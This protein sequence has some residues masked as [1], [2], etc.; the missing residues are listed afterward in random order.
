MTAALSW[1]TMIA[2]F[3]T[4][5]HRSEVCYWRFGLLIFAITTRAD[6]GLSRDRI[7][8]LVSRT[9]TSFASNSPEQCDLF[10]RISK[11][12]W[13]YRGPCNF[14]ESGSQTNRLMPCRSPSYER[15]LT[16]ASHPW[17]LRRVPVKSSYLR[18]DI[19]S[20][21][22]SS[23]LS[24]CTVII[25]ERSLPTHSVLDSP[26]P[27]LEMQS[28]LFCRSCFLGDRWLSFLFRFFLFSFFSFWVFSFSRRLFTVRH[29][30]SFWLVFLLFRSLLDGYVEILRC[31]MLSLR[32]GIWIANLETVSSIPVPVESFSPL[33]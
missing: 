8:S 33:P 12:V 7:R 1:T 24:A 6:A 23:R 20:T 2:V 17:T 3:N 28:T 19:S 4:T 26:S 16:F 21:L 14:I 15:V 9:C 29:L 25:L 27:S 13:T 11:T 10:C 5:F 30:L 31:I 18:M 32:M 22:E